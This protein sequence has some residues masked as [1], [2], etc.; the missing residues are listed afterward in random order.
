MV[1]IDADP[2]ASPWLKLPQDLQCGALIVYSI[3]TR[4]KPPQSLLELYEQAPIKGLT[5]QRWSS[6]RSPMIDLNWAI[7]P[8]QRSCPFTATA[9]HD[10]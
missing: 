1:F 2:A 8:A 9:G 7:L 5:E 4:G 3:Q 6:E 10:G